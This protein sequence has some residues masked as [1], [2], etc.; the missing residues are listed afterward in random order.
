[1]DPNCEIDETSDKCPLC[2]AMPGQ[3]V[4]NRL[5]YIL[6]TLCALTAVSTLAVG[7]IVFAHI[8][9]SAKCAAC[10][11]FNA[12]EN[13]FC[14]RCGERIVDLQSRPLP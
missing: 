12:R 2:G 7:W 5:R 14:A 4:S 3:T 1:M 11:S 10:G 9:R 6:I 8:H 13:Q